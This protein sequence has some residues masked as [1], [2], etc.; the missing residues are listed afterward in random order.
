MSCIFVSDFGLENFG[1]YFRSVLACV[2]P[3]IGVRDCGLIP[4]FYAASALSVAFAP[5][6]M[7]TP[8]AAS[9]FEMPRNAIFVIG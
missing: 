5:L 2:K 1:A 9:A 3:T 4:L 6:S 8:L 7:S